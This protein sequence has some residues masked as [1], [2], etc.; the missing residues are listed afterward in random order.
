MSWRQKFIGR[1]KNI[2]L[3]MSL[4]PGE[5]VAIVLIS[6]FKKYRPVGTK[7]KGNQLTGFYMMAPLAFDEVSELINFY[8]SLKLSE[9]QW[10]LGE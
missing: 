8:F 2:A 4:L 10:F 1:Y 7:L 5:K 6:I 3:K 9:N